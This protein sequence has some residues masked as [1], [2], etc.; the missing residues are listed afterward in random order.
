LKRVIGILLDSKPFSGIQ[1]S[2]TG[3]E[4]IAFYNKA[5]KKHGLVPFY[6]CLHLVKPEKRKVTGYLFKNGR[7]LLKERSLPPVIHNR[8]MP[9]SREGRQRLEALS[10]SSLVFNGRTRYSKW[11]IHRILNKK[12]ALQPYLPY[13]LLFSKSSLSKMMERYSAIYVK[14]VSSSIG[15]GIIKVSRVSS[16][17]WRI[18][19]A[20]NI[21]TKKM[22]KVYPYL[23]KRIGARSY[24]IQEAIPLAE[25]KG[26]PFDIRVSVQKNGH[27]VWQ[28]TG[29]VGKVAGK[30]RH[31][32]NVAQG[33]R[34]IRCDTL[35]SASGIPLE[36]TERS[37]KRI[38][39]KIAK[40]LE[41]K[42]KNLADVGLDM[43]VDQKGHPYFIEM[44]GRDLRYSFQEGGLQKKFYKTYE[45]PVKYAKYL[46]KRKG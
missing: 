13:T 43:G 24:I 6:M 23:R 46:Y 7:Y 11:K 9:M 18:Q 41:K 40:R 22:K 12:K 8:A 28:V 16:R 25:Y 14:P 45:N 30:G 37:I 1:K 26:R 38:S 2:R 21:Q 36:P 17:D 27:G 31:V 4:K 44:N 15:K 10:Q 29:M 19:T 5:T 32:T 20:G 34:V 39:L 33:G 42:L 35:F 3:R